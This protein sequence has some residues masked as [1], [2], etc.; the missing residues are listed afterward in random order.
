MACQIAV[1][2]VLAVSC[3]QGQA[4]NITLGL[5][6]PLHP[7][8][9]PYL[10][11]GNAAGLT[12]TLDHEHDVLLGRGMLLHFLPCQRLYLLEKL[13]LIPGTGTAVEDD[14]LQYISVSDIADIMPS[15]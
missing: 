13:H 10:Q 15:V 2:I 14:A 7:A 1:R 5:V 3:V 11:V 8:Q 9:Y 6:V 4:A 12:D